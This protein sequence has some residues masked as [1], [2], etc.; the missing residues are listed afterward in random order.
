M[1][2]RQLLWTFLVAV[3]LTLLSLF[4]LDQPIAAFVQRVGGRQSV[5]LQGGTRWLEIASGFPIGKF[6]LSYVLLGAAALFFIAPSTRSVA[7]MLLFIGGSQLVTRLI[8][9]GLKDVF[10][11]LRPFE[12]IQAG[13]WDWK[14]FTG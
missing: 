1:N 10:Q 12:V 6:F 9:G 13:N 3:V 4:F 7:W 8:V 11:R 5:I 14:F 2:R